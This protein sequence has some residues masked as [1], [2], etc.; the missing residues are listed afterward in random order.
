MRLERHI[1]KSFSL[2]AKRM[3]K[4]HRKPPARRYRGLQPTIE[5]HPCPAGTLLEA[6]VGHLALTRLISAVPIER[7]AACDAAWLGV[8]QGTSGTVDVSCHADS[9]EFSWQSAG[10]PRSLVTST[11]PAEPV[12]SL[13][14]M[15][16]VDHRIIGA[17]AHCSEVVDHQALR[18]SLA[19]VQ[20]DGRS[21]TVVG[22]DG[23]QLLRYDSFAFPWQEAA[24]LVPASQVFASPL[25]AH[26]QSVQCGL[27]ARELVIQVEPW[28]LRLPL[29]LEGRYPNV[30]AVI[31]SHQ[32]PT[33]RVFFDAGDLAFFTKHA[34][35]LPGNQREHAPVTLRLN[36]KVDIL[37]AGDAAQRPLRLRLSRSYQLGD[38]YDC[39]VNRQHLLTAAKL[40]LC[41]LQRFG[42][43]GPLVARGPHI[44]YAWQPL[45]GVKPPEETDDM[46]S[47][48]TPRS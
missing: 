42:N 6:R 17:L 47:I 38:E 10:L 45:S 15:N 43:H 46:L 14:S 40:Q 27:A 41:D 18:Y 16:P 1:I 11:T 24:I 19:Y 23:T 13:P 21:G 3:F 25:L 33:G 22:T 4:V 20:L 5:L 29:Q 36:G 48:E 44:T 39:S 31:S 34:E 9:L 35:E 30:E 37:A 2:L 32:H 7:A 12:S 8:C 28:T 26:C